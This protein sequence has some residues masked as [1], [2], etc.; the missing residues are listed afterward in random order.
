MP[1][2]VRK[3]KRQEPFAGPNRDD[4]FSLGL[5]LVQQQQTEIPQRAPYPQIYSSCSTRGNTVRHL[6]KK[7]RFSNRKVFYFI[8]KY[9][10]QRA[11][12]KPKQE[13]SW[14]LQTSGHHL[15]TFLFAKSV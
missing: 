8:F 14:S 10:Q 1:N 15:Q 13:N 5:F 9:F 3:W 12:K 4:I 6:D 2:T 7:K 11:R